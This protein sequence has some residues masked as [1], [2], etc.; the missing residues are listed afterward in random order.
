MEHGIPAH[1]SSIV[2]LLRY[3]ASEASGSRDRPAYT[4]LEDGREVT[5]QITFGQLR[6]RAEV[7]ATHLQ[8]HTRPGD[9]VVLAH[10]VSL[11]YI[12]SFFACAC[13][14]VIAVPAV[15]PTNT[16]MLPRLKHL[17]RDSGPSAILASRAGVDRLARLNA[18]AG[19]PLDGVALI[20]SDDPDMPERGWVDPGTRGEDI[21]FLQYTS[22]STGSP[23][24]VMV[25]HRNLFANMSLFQSTL[26]LEVGDVLVS[27]LPPY[28]DFGLMCGI[29][30]PLY[31]GL[32]AVHMPPSVFMRRPLRWLK[33]ASDYRAA[34]TGAPNFAFQHCVEGISAEEK[35][36]L[37]L[38]GLRYTI[39]GAERV[40]AET[41]DAFA[42][43]F[44]DCGF[45]AEAMTPGY[46]LAEATLAFSM[47]VGSSHHT[48]SVKR[49]ALAAH[50]IEPA[51]DEADCIRLVSNGRAH[52]AMHDVRIVD[53]ET[54]RPLASGEVGEVW[55]RGPS[56][57]EGYWKK[58]EATAQTFRVNTADGEAGFLRTGDL[59]FL[60]DGE[61]FLTGRRKEI[62][63]FGGRNFYPQDI[64]ATVEAVDPALRSNGS[65]AFAHEPPDG[66]ARLIL[67]LEVESRK[68]P[69]TADIAARIQAALLEEHELQELAAILLVKPG[70]IPR[71]SSGKIERLRCCELYLAG[72]LEPMWRWERTAGT[73][74]GSRLPATRVERRVAALVGRILEREVPWADADLFA[75]GL[76]SL[77]AMETLAR[78]ETEFGIA[79]TPEALFS[80]PTVEG[81]A[82]AVEARR[83]EVPATAVDATDAES[84][85]EAFPLTHMQRQIWWVG[86]MGQ[87]AAQA[88][89]LATA[90][91]MD[92]VLEIDALAAA[93]DEL[94]RRREALRVAFVEEDGIV[95]QRIVDVPAHALEVI[96][97]RASEHDAWS[98]FLSTRVAMP[99]D[100]A[101]GRPFR[102]CLARLPEGRH[103][104]LIEQHH[105]VSDAWAAGVLFAELAALYDVHRQ[106]QVGP[107]PPVMPY[108]QILRDGILRQEGAQEERHLSYWREHLRGAP[109]VIDLPLDRPRPRRQSYRGSRVPLALSSA[110]IDKLH[111]FSRTHGTTVFM[112]LLAAWATQLSRISGQADVVIGVPFA[113]RHRPGASDWSALLTNIQ[114]LRMHI[115]A[116]SSVRDC[117][118]QAKRVVLEGLAHQDV[119]FS[120]VVHALN[121]RRSGSHSPVFQVMLVLDNAPL[122]KAPYL[123]G[124]RCE[125][126]ETALPG[127][128]YDLVLTL[129][130]RDGTMA[131]HLE[132]SSA[133]LDRTTVEAMAGQFLHMLGAFLANPD[134][135][136]VR[137][138]LMD[139]AAWQT[140][141]DRHAA[142]ESTWNPRQHVSV[143]FGQQVVRHPM[144]RAIKDA[145][146]QVSYGQLDRRA[147][148]VAWRLRDVGV[149]PGDRVVVCGTRSARLVACLLGVFK[150]GATYVPLPA[151]LPRERMAYILADAFPR[152]VLCTDDAP[153]TPTLRELA[154]STTTP[155]YL[156][157]DDESEE[158][159]DAD[160]LGLSP[161]HP[162]YVIYTSGSTGQPKGVVN[163]HAGLANRLLWARERVLAP[164]PSCAFKTHIGF[165][166]SVTEMLQPLLSGGELCVFD[167]R[168]ARD[169]GR[170]AQQL[171]AERISH[172]V[173][174]PSLLQVLL[175]RHAAELASVRAVV[176]SGERLPG[177]LV[178]QMRERCPHTRL[179]NFYGSSEAN[180]D[181]VFH[182]HEEAP[183]AVDGQRS[184]IGRPIANT[185][186][187]VLDAAG[188]PV[189][190]GVTGEIHVGGVGVALGYLNRPA[191]T[192]ERFLPDPFT[193]EA[194]ASM[195]RTGDLGRWRRD[196]T[197]EYLGRNDFQVKLRGFRIEPGEIEAHL[198]AQPGIRQAVVLVRQER[199]V[200]YVVGDGTPPF[201]PD[202]LRAVLAK[203]LP[204]YML[205]SAYMSLDALP[206]TP[207]GKLD[208]NA[209]PAPGLQSLTQH[210]YEAPQGDIEQLLAELWRELLNME[211]V[212]R[213]DHFFELGGHSLLAVRLV[214]RI[215]QAC[216]VELDL[217][218][219]FAHPRL[220]ALARAVREAAVS[221]LPPLS[222]V[223]RGED[224]PLSWSQ[225]RLW[226]LDRLDRA[227]SQAYHIAASLRLR[228]DLDGDA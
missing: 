56:M 213:Q 226:F 128:A 165:V 211:R 140:W 121:P 171:V 113:N 42:A 28:H 183:D 223:D 153:A 64:E 185:R 102:A 82:A 198:V 116:Q 227:S 3:R 142:S 55:L 23:K 212:G 208:R 41:L 86:R 30:Y 214:S 166:D 29:C 66:A 120:D 215:R 148:R 32:H 19:G 122:P 225:Q 63:I 210:A 205:P 193:D 47:H 141:Q 26:G 5:D 38:S 1:I 61:L 176:C 70:R 68:T 67:V 175:E 123:E 191:L 146:A 4:F 138:P 43:A 177:A 222:A 131:G 24:G 173:L 179:F 62:M 124:L 190:E 12:I 31:R 119:A 48:L 81:I 59:G 181:S 158:A 172:L 25:S 37:D 187:Y 157:D 169:P 11:D 194:H 94:V 20:A 8:A 167:A 126:V 54:R 188:Q 108:A 69:R 163:T 110:L 151:D 60:R 85:D 203:A 109:D 88:F 155:L 21:L 49:T 90:C 45:R 91:R 156:C 139:E 118:M 217:R 18:D 112:T 50:R 150:A 104:L 46:G 154:Q 218:E 95:V 22:G 145:Q 80:A 152:L 136:A 132:Y 9:R 93:F 75:S 76:T 159:P 77:A 209:L 96:D 117:V 100:L 111:V 17:V 39:N 125:P 74:D 27:W 178:R 196:G 162:A 216:G 199:L 170:F 57:A 72:E 35:A 73:Q 219:L 71:T 143:L 130:E 52:D 44:A 106:G 200:A 2:D 79:V 189:P 201:Q 133:L 224:P 34:L 160:A 186:I 192:A 204:D 135:E 195:Y 180:G 161:D 33:A 221:E 184:I 207:S 127:V 6:A 13:A 58:P 15:P 105:L 97:L 220:E 78:V 10:S 129:S 7:L 53:P 115:D 36:T 40:R 14:G 174:V 99:F 103:G 114:A 87:D 84:A 182:E 168:T 83:V 197:L 89:H 137:V 134:G 206:L 51:I 101:S 92:G 65:A 144:R 107:L 16:R 149:R 147:N 228:G 164:N 98:R 202:E